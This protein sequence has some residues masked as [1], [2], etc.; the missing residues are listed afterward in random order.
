[1]PIEYVDAVKPYVSRQVWFVAQLQ[2]LTGARGGELLKMR[3][4]DLDTTG[5]L[6][7]YTLAAHKTRHFGHERLI[8]L[9]PRAQIIVRPFL[10]GRATDAFIFSAAEAEAERRTARHSARKTPLSCGNRPGS[11][12]RR[13]PRR[14]PADRYA[15]ASY[16]RAIARA[17]KLA[18]VP[19]WHPHQLRHTTATDIRKRFG[20]EAARV[21]LGHRSPAV[22]ELY[23]EIDRGKAEHVIAAVG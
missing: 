20:V 22:T 9:G 23:A 16:R 6:W 1:M 5:E 14:Q 10:A 2:L 13:K 4:C 15:P 17:C 3:P 12:R 19:E 7:V 11:N 21:V 8:L 18:G